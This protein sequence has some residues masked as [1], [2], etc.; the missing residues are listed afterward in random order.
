METGFSTRKRHES[1]CRGAR[2]LYEAVTTTLG[3]RGRNVII[4]KG[5]PPKVTHDGVTVAKSIDIEV[6]DDDT[7]GSKSRC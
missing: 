6:I 3:A 7:L 4:G 5:F 2:I 1:A